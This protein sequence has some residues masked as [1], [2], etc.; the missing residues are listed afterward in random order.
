MKSIRIIKET[1]DL[2]PNR[3]KVLKV[4]MVFTCTDEL[5]EEYIS[6]KL[7]EE[8]G[9]EIVKIEQEKVEQKLEKDLEEKDEN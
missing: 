9:P 2:R 8:V 7:A 4:G 6:K 5:A 1:E 3:K